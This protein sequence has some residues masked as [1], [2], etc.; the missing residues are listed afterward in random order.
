MTEEPTRADIS[1]RAGDCSRDV[2]AL[3][4]PRDPDLP[5]PPPAVSGREAVRN[6][7]YLDAYRRFDS[8]N[9][10]PCAFCGVPALPWMRYCP[11]CGR[12]VFPDPG[13]HSG[14]G[15]FPVPAKDTGDPVKRRAR[16]LHTNMLLQIF[17]MLAVP[18]TGLLALVFAAL[19]AGSVLHAALSML[20][21]KLLGPALTVILGLDFGSG[22]LAQLQGE[23]L[24]LAAE[25][26]E[27]A[28]FWAETF[29][30]S[31]FAVL[32]FFGLWAL[33][34]SGG[35]FRVFAARD[36]PEQHRLV[37]GTFLAALL[38]V[39]AS[40]A[41]VAVIY[42]SWNFM[43]L[44]AAFN[45]AVLAG[46]WLLCRFFAVK[47]ALRRFYRGEPPARP[48]RLWPVAGVGSA[49]LCLLALDVLASPLL[50]M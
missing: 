44:L 9:T 46:T 38:A 21:K 34:I 16:L 17:V 7:F 28:L 49:L 33:A 29:V 18:A 37:L 32:L 24:S 11:L 26:G 6:D 22:T 20:A 45:V 50:L 12:P 8:R 31:P 19:N 43:L 47:G 14:D 13:N 39:L 41:A 5:K 15:G 1:C 2:P 10:V 48:G 35:S 36:Y 42:T 27:K 4:Q 23:Y 30:A 3:S 25:Y 40:G